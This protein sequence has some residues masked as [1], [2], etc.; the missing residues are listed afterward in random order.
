MSW[1]GAEEGRFRVVGGEAR[2]PP[3]HRRGAARSRPQAAQAPTGRCREPPVSLPGA[4][5]A[6]PGE[7]DYVKAG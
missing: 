3:R 6:P 7:A 5:G 4:A 2:K 1:R